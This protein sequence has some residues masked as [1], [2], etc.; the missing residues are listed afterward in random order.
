[1]NGSNGNVA[2]VIARVEIV[3]FENGQLGYKHQ[4]PSRFVFNAMMETAK[5][6]I[7]SELM[8]A[9]QQKVKLPDVDVSRIK[10]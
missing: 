8:Q 6:N 2:N 3:L 4:L 7:L 9:E 10:L 1:M 5:Q